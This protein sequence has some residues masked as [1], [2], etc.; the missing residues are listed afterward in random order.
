MKYELRNI[1]YIFFIKVIP[2][3][4]SEIKPSHRGHNPFFSKL[5]KS[6]KDLLYIIEIKLPIL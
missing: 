2:N 4:K 6:L 1:L 5:K 3:E